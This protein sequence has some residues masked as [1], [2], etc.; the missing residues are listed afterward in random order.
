MAKIRKPIEVFSPALF[1]I[2]LEGDVGMGGVP[3]GYA[4]QFLAGEGGADGRRRMGM[5]RDSRCRVGRG[6]RR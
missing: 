1:S 6:D 5:L 3:A 4:C 2:L